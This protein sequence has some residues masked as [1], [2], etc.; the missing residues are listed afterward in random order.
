MKKIISALSLFSILLTSAC[1]QSDNQLPLLTDTNNGVEISAKKTKNTIRTDWYETLRP[2]LQAYYA[3][4]KGKT[5]AELFDAL[6][7]VI[8]KGAKVSDYKSAKSFMYSTAD[9]IKVNG[10]SGVYD[11]YSYIFVPGSGGDGNSYTESADENQD[12][13]PRD[14]INCEHTWPQSFFNKKAPMVADL[15]HL[16]PTMSVPNEMRN[17]FPI[18]MVKGLI[19]YTTNGGSRLSLIDKTSKNRTVETT[20]KFTSR[21]KV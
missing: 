19:P 10:K 21:R 16:F 11:A 4:A 14:F 5:G 13:H 2:D 20:F 1:G 12:G 7:N 17:H 9:N 6:N 15:H 8:S 3:P 18:G